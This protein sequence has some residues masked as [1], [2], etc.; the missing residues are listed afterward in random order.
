MLELR[1]RW[2][3]GTLASAEDGE[4]EATYTGGRSIISGVRNDRWIMKE[5]KLDVERV[6]RGWR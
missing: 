4:R 3:D 1:S 2:C 6:C 5:Y